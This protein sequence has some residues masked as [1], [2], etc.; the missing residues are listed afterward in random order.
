MKKSLRALTII[1]ALSASFASH[2]ATWRGVFAGG[3]RDPPT[4][5]NGWTSATVQQAL[6]KSAVVPV[7]VESEKSAPVTVAK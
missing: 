7:Q 2:A 5:T 3:N 6:P 4:G 1:V